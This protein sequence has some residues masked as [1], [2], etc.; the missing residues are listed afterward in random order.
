MFLISGNSEYIDYIDLSAVVADYE[1]DPYGSS[2][3]DSI[4]W[5]TVSKSLTGYNIIGT[6]QTS[7]QVGGLSNINYDYARY[8]AVASYGKY[9]WL[10]AGLDDYDNTYKSD[11]TV[12]DL[13][14]M[15]FEYVGNYK[16]GVSSGEAIFVNGIVY[17]WGGWDGTYNSDHI[18]YFKTDLFDG[19]NTEIT[20]TYSTPVTTGAIS[21]TDSN[22]NAT[23]GEPNSNDEELNTNENTMHNCKVY[24][25]F[26]VY[27]CICRVYT[28]KYITSILKINIQNS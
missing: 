17:M 18:G 16:Y 8:V 6:G 15:E 4:E 23:K 20:D 11:V 1:N 12:I 14:T 19:T 7:D 9:I 24:G 22:N 27:M 13:D 25:I 3:L 28:F 2:I 21:V 26:W 5:K 10:I